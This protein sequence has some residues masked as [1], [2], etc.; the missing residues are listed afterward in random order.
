MENFYRFNRLILIAG[1]FILASAC[2]QDQQAEVAPIHTKPESI[3]G[4]DPQAQ[5]A[6]KGSQEYTTYLI[7]K[8]QHS[9][10]SSSFKSLRTKSLV[11]DAIFDNSAIYTS[12]DPVNQ[13]DINKLYGLADCGTEHQTNSARFGWRWFNNSLQLFAYVYYNR[14][15]ASEYITTIDLNKAYRYELVLDGYN[16]IFRVNGQEVIMPR[17]CSGT[18]LGYQLYPYFGGDEVAPHDITIKIRKQN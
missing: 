11:F 14:I 12:I 15:R 3:A 4:V 16:Y 17:G 18:G 13:A 7:R 10:T 8:G 6:R 9:T 5:N 2:E 1:V